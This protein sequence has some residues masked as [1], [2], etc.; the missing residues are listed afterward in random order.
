MLMKDRLEQVRTAARIL[1]ALCGAER[2]MALGAFAELLIEDAAIL[3]DANKKDLEENRRN[4]APALFDRLKFDH[5]KLRALVSG[6]KDLAEMPDPLGRNL[7]S[8]LLDDGLTLEKIV[9]PLGVIGVIFESRPDVLP[10]LAA[11]ALRSGNGLILKGGAEASHTNLAMMETIRRVSD[12]VPAIPADWIVLF[13][14]REA[15]HEMLRLPE[16]IDLIIPRGGNELVRSIRAESEIPVLGHAEGVCHI[17]V[18]ASAASE[19]ALRVIIDAKTQYP[20]ACNSV[21]TVLVDD[22]IAA[23]FLPQLARM[24]A[25]KGV[26]LRGDKRVKEIIPAATTIAECDWSTEYG[27]LTIALKLVSNLSQAVEHINRYGSHHTDGI[28][29][30]D[31]RVQEEFAA[32]VDSA[33]VMVNCSTRFADGYRYGFGAEVGISTGKIHARGPV[34]VEGL[35]SY[36][37]IVRGEGQVVSD[38]VGKDARPFKHEKEPQRSQ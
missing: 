37:Y 29:A 6:I 28:I 18:H 26:A 33:S 24:L 3:T 10:Q 1:G 31:S 32:L 35:L 30:A 7:A 20:S 13:N 27:D 2:S 38:Y 15:V 12:R 16:H 21:E 14:T 25:E 4:L 22:A 17:Y 36:K 5:D 19:L 23:T 9:V 8:T 34:G 11:L